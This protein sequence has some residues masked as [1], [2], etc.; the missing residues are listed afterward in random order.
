MIRV[1]L[2]VASF[3]CVAIAGGCVSPVA[4]RD[5]REPGWQDT[6]TPAPPIGIDRLAH[7][8]VDEDGGLWEERAS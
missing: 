3:A 6:G 1:S 2:L 4:H 5:A 8:Y 7:Y